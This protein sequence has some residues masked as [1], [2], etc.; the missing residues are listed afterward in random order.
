MSRPRIGRRSSAAAQAPPLGG[1]GG[2]LAR[3]SQVFIFPN[4]AVTDAGRP[5]KRVAVGVRWLS[6]AE[7]IPKGR[8]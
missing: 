4:G 1:T 7:A 8:G 3:D 6:V 2:R 5:G